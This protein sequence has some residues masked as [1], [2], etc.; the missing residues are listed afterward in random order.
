MR[1]SGILASKGSTVA[2][3]APQET[4]ATAVE[5][6]RQFGIGALVVSADGN[7]IDG[8]V[9]ERDVVLRLA[10][11]GDAV[12]HLPVSAVMTSEVRTCALEDCVEDLM[13]EMTEHRT[14][15]LPVAVDGVLSGIISIGDVVKWRV[16]E[17][18]EEKRHLTDYI[19]TGR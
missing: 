18:E 9:S 19:V 17:L 8:I 5:Q 10:T 4:L 14:R 7:R 3:I 15:H 1:V 6:L 12:L 11:D 2:T 16:T 13:R